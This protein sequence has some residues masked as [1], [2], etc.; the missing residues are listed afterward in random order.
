MYKSCKC[1]APAAAHT[2]LLLQRAARPTPAAAATNSSKPQ[3]QHAQ[4]SS[5]GMVL[6]Q[7]CPL[8][9]LC[10]YNKRLH[11][12]GAKLLCSLQAT[13]LLDSHRDLD[14]HCSQLSRQVLEHIRHRHALDPGA[15]VVAEPAHHLSLT[16]ALQAAEEAQQRH[17]SSSSAS[18]IRQGL[19]SSTSNMQPLKQCGQVYAI[20]SNP[21]LLQTSQSCNDTSLVQPTCT[22]DMTPVSSPRMAAAL[23]S[24]ARMLPQR[25]HTSHTW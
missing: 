7:H 5:Y 23:L 4:A 9:G 1:V 12:A 24:G 18:A 17:S 8:A 19:S 11:S 21:P 2:T 22:P 16:S 10:H 15:A 6:L 20:Q 25:V 3:P 13:Q 14:V